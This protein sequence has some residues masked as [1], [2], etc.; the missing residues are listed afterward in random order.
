MNNIN[1]QSRAEQIFT[2]QTLELDKCF[3]AVEDDWERK[4]RAFLHIEEYKTHFMMIWPVY[5][6]K[7]ETVKS[8][9]SLIPNPLNDLVYNMLTIA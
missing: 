4:L 1:E 5:D 3:F 8:I 6:H 7:D 2:L 9:L